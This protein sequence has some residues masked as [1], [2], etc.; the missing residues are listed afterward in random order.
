MPNPEAIRVFE[1]TKKE[2]LGAK[3]E[4]TTAVEADAF[5]EAL[6]K[7]RVKLFERYGLEAMPH[8]RGEQNFGWDIRPGIFRPP[9][10][11]PDAK[12]GKELERKAV[13]EFENV[14]KTKV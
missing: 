5:H 14:I 6:I 2:I 12:T 8:Y 10:K 9:L 7:L 11:I 1:L 3:N 4:I 13:A